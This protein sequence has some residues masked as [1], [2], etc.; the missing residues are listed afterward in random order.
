MSYVE[1]DCC[2]L[3]LEPI[4]GGSLIS[5]YRTEGE[6]PPPHWF[7]CSFGGK[8]Y[9]P[10]RFKDGGR[11]R[12]RMKCAASKDFSGEV[13]KWIKDQSRNGDSFR[14]NPD[15]NTLSPSIPYPIAYFLHH[16]DGRVS[17]G[18]I[19]HHNNTCAPK[20]HFSPLNLLFSF[21]DRKNP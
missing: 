10:M 15:P 5:Q 18:F 12:Y 19:S 16:S 2:F 9:P 3:T 8:G 21:P 17:A 7:L 13:G 14:I 20:L 11:F 1:Q 6:E 4:D